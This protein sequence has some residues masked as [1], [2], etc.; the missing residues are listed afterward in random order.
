[1][2]TRTE[3]TMRTGAAVAVDGLRGRRTP[4][5][6]RIRTDMAAVLVDLGCGDSIRGR[7]H[8]LSV[9][10]MFF[11][12][13]DAPEVGAHVLCALVWADGGYQNEFHANGT[14]VHRDGHGVGIAF[15]EVTPQ[16]FTVIS[17]IIADAGC[18]R[19]RSVEH[20]PVARERRGGPLR[21]S[22]R[23][24]PVNRSDKALRAA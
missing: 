18:F 23:G 3:M 12:G 13:R 4:L 19:M 14:V 17:D 7:V 2:G 6:V 24:A 1:M 15:E 10:G 5:F 8:N 20:H 9:G 22:H 16:A 21:P 11:S